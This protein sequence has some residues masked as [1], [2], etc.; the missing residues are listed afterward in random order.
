LVEEDNSLGAKE[1]DSS[2]RLLEA[3]SNRDTA[4]V[5]LLL[6]KKDIEP[7][8]RDTKYGRTPLLLALEMG[9][10]AVVKLLLATNSAN[11][12]SKDTIYS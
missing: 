5:K 8:S 12:N 2:A 9:H 11:P 4:A 10:K 1:G 3:A 7:N 6:S